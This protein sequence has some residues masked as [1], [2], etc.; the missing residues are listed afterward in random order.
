MK[1]GL[2]A[3]AAETERTSISI[4]SNT[5]IE[6]RRIVD[7]LSKYNG[8]TV[9]KCAHAHYLFSTH[10]KASI[11]RG[12]LAAQPKIFSTIC[13]RGLLAAY[14]NVFLIPYISVIVKLIFDF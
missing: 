2:W 1:W 13:L 14:P 7:L 9:K 6:N 12:L 8:N 10:S 5:A 4:A 11:Q 3:K